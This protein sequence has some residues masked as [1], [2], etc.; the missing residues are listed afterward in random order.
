MKAKIVAAALGLG[1]VVG[2]LVGGTQV[3]AAPGGGAK[4]VATSNYA[5]DCETKV[6]T[7][8]LNLRKGPGT[9]YEVIWVMQE[10]LEVQADL[11]PEMHQ[12]GFVHIS[13]DEGENY[14]WAYEAYL[15]DPGSGSGSSDDGDWGEDDAF[16]SGVAQTTSRVN[17]RT[18]PGTGYDVQLVIEE[19]AKLGYTDLVVNGFRYVGYTGIDGWVYDAYI[20]PVG[21][22]GVQ[23]G[24]YATTTSNLNLREQPNLGADVL[25]VIPDGGSVL[26]GAENE[27]GFRAVT[28]NGITGWAYETY[29]A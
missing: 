8:S 25:L 18:G 22:Y 1:M 15:A 26:V 16:L 24:T 23:P 27:N 12:N 10:G 29:L 7:S 11:R 14:G 5:C 21:G 3:G 2:S 13:W 28:Y 20:D 6:V 9:N 4:S 17:F 19:G